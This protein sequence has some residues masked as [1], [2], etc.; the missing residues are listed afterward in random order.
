MAGLL[1]VA[2][3]CRQ[4]GPRAVDTAASRESAKD[5]TPI[6]LASFAEPPAT[7][8][9]KKDQPSTQGA[10]QQSPRPAAYTA[11]GAAFQQLAMAAV[12]GAVATVPDAGGAGKEAAESLVFAQQGTAGRIGLAASATTSSGS[13]VSSSGLGE[14]QASRFGFA[15]ANNIFSA[16]VNRAS[17]PGG[18]CGEL[19]GAGF[20]GG[21]R[22]QCEISIRSVR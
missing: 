22:P 12:A 21:S 5:L 15:S 2:A 14:G 10:T 18:R 3:G 8:E 11:P 17:G 9:E 16:Q 1:L 6:R 20:F 13:I 19:A 7:G 4:A